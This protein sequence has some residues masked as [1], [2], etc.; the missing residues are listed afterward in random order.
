MKKIL[1]ILLVV[2]LFFAV[3]T[4]YAILIGGPGPPGFGNDDNSTYFSTNNSIV[5]IEIND[6]GGIG[7]G[8]EFG[9][10]F[11]GFPATRIPIFEPADEDGEVALIDF[12]NAIGFVF[13][14][15]DAAVQSIFNNQFN[16]IGFYLEFNSNIFHTDPALNPGGLDFAAT[17]RNLN[18]PELYLIGFELPG[19]DIVLSLDLISGV[20][21]VPEPGTLLL[22]G[23]AI[24]GLGAYRRRTN[25][26]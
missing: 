15:E 2:S 14:V 6:L 16:D 26:K 17:F 7:T 12:N 24:F 25:R 11:E 22:L 23:S 20:R 3:N 21:S 1:F 9:F 13:D 8:T 18:N 5:G 10:F 4:S 19:Q